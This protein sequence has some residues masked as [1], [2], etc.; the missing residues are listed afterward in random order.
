MWVCLNNAFV[1]IV[2]NRN[3]PGDL[4]IRARRKGDIEKFMGENFV[5][6][7]ETPLADYRFR[8]SVEAD[9][10]SKV[11]ADMVYTIDYDNF[12][13]SVK[14][15]DLHDAYSGFWSIMYRLQDKLNSVAKKI[16]KKVI[17]IKNPVT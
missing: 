13:D 7:I 14:D 6:V 10:V 16:G 5:R 4:M 8:A 15:K 9:L 2:A 17:R 11:M 12:K 3:R 1:S